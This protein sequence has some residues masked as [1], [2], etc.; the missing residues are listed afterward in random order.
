V[1]WLIVQRIRSSTSTDEEPPPLPSA[2]P[3]PLDFNYTRSTSFT[4]DDSLPTPPP[5]H[6]TTSGPQK[7]TSGPQ[8]VPSG[9]QGRDT[10]RDEHFRRRMEFLGLKPEDSEEYRK[11]KEG[12]QPI[13]VRLND[14]ECFFF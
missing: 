1:C 6:A 13:A 5:A 7:S 2:P 14:N 8:L 12:K 9:P 4:S 10:D 11:V 3:P